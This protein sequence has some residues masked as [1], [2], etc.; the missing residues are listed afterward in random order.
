MEGNPFQ[1]FE[2]AA[3]LLANTPG[4]YEIEKSK[5]LAT[6]AL[7]YEAR[8]ANLIAM[9]QLVIAVDGPTADLEADFAAITTRLGL[10]TPGV[11]SGD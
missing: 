1:H 6:L 2:E 5:A 9:A 7:A 4:E 3:A 11:V 10:N 8:T